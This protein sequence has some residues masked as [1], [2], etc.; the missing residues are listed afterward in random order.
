MPF[1]QVNVSQKLEVQQKEYVKAILGELITLIPGKTEAVTMI[2]LA[3]DR[4]IYKGGKPVEGGFIE[5]RLYGAAE[6]SSKE[7]LTEAI[8]SA[9]EQLLGIQPQNLYINI[10]EMNSWGSNGR[11]K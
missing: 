4:S 9:M 10:L 11:L 6:Q 8:F 5:V 3:D 7:A 2:D 1:I